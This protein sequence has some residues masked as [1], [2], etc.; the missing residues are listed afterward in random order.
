MEGK[1]KG[2][3]VMRWCPWP[4]APAGPIPTPILAQPGPPACLKDGKTKYKIPGREYTLM[5]EVLEDLSCDKLKERLRTLGEKV[6]G[7]K[8][9][10]IK[11]LRDREA[12]TKKFLRD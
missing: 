9:A 10:L 11:R 4:M 8:P 12:V 2:D 6:G 1:L 3:G 7:N 5:P